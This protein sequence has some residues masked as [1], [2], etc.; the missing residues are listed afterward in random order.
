MRRIPVAFWRAFTLIELLVVVAIIAIL[1]AM[2]LPALAA[3]R[4]KARRASCLNNL[5]QTAKAFESYLGDYG[6]YFPPAPGW[7]PTEMYPFTD[8]GPGPWRMSI[9]SPTG[10]GGA[11]TYSIRIKG[12]SG[13]ANC[14]AGVNMYGTNTNYK[15]IYFPDGTVKA[16]SEVWDDNVTPKRWV[17]GYGCLTTGGYMTAEPFFCQSA[18]GLTAGRPKWWVVKGGYSHWD[19]GVFKTL[20]GADGKSLIYGAGQVGHIM[21]SYF[22]RNVGFQEK[23]DHYRGTDPRYPWAP[24]GIDDPLRYP[25]NDGFFDY[26]LP[27]VYPTPG[28]PLFKTQKIL[29]GR[30]LMAD[31]FLRVIHWRDAASS[32]DHKYYDY[33]TRPGYGQ[34]A[35]RDGYNALYGDW[36]GSWYGDPQERIVYWSSYWGKSSTSYASYSYFFDYRFWSGYTSDPNVVVYPLVGLSGGTLSAHEVWH[37]F[38]LSHRLDDRPTRVNWP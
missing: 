3:A 35:H 37:Q 30:A 38:D 9:Y 22:Y 16:L 18:D 11:G 2:L 19:R 1:A 36:S 23:G 20:G 14:F 32:D 12:F 26:V 10:A 4:E 5:N 7:D 25:D 8:Q 33:P 24:R 17:S 31:S 6:G 27:K 21:G 15:G 34:Y 28:V 13:I 29:G